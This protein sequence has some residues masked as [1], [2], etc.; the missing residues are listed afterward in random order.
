MKIAEVQEAEN[1]RI[2]RSFFMIL[3]EEVLLGTLITMAPTVFEKIHFKGYFSHSQTS[4]F[5]MI[6]GEDLLLGMVIT[7]LRTVFGK[8]DFKGYLSQS[9]TPEFLMLFLNSV[10]WPW[11]KIL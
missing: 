4:N 11:T 7:I 10:T 9:Q 3:G 1:T 8:I 5:F 6:L 2:Y